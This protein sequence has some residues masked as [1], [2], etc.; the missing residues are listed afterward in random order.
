MTESGAAGQRDSGIRRRG[1]LGRGAPNA[2]TEKL[3][4][5]D[6]SGL[7]GLTLL[8]D[9]HNYSQLN[10][11]HWFSSN[12]KSEL[13]FLSP[14]HRSESETFFAQTSHAFPEVSQFV[15]TILP[16]TQVVPQAQSKSTLPGHTQNRWVRYN[17][18]R[19]PVR[20]TVTVVVGTNLVLR[21][22]AVCDIGD[23]TEEDLLV[24]VWIRACKGGK[25]RS[26]CI[27]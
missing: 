3:A 8:H 12:F 24:A 23:G 4:R 6:C 11:Y 19:L 5:T 26:C 22:V 17:G 7:L 9:E 1:R 27:I 18:K 14:L 20:R 16:S 2:E 10:I 21:F 25:C 13:Q 15:A